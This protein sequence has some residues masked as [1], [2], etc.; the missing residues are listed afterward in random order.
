[1]SSPVGASKTVKPTK[2]TDENIK[3][4]VKCYLDNDTEHPLFNGLPPIKNWDVSKVKRMDNLFSGRTDF[5]EDLSKWKVENVTNMSSMFAGCVNFK[6]NLSKWKVSKV[7]FMSNMFA[8]CVEFTSNLS[9]WDVSAVTDMNHMFTGCA[10]FTSDVSKWAVD[11]VNFMQNMFDGCSKFN[12]NVSKWNV[13]NVNNFDAMFRGCAIFNCDL[14]NWNVGNAMSMLNMFADCTNFT[15]DLCRWDTQKATKMTRK[16]ISD[17]YTRSKLTL[18]TIPY[19]AAT[20][21][22]KSDKMFFAD[23]GIIEHQK[24]YVYYKCGQYRKI[25]YDRMT[26]CDAIALYQY[27]FDGYINNLLRTNSD[28]TN[29]NL[30]EFLHAIIRV[31]DD[32]HAGPAPR[33]TE[34]MVKMRQHLVYRGEKT[35]CKGGTCRQGIMPSYTSSSTN[36]FIAIGFM[37]KTSTNG[38]PCCLYE[39]ALNVGTPY[40]DVDSIMAN[41]RV[42]CGAY[43]NVPLGQERE[44]ILPRGITILPYK[45]TTQSTFS[46]SM[47]V[48]T[49]NVTYDTTYV[50]NNSMSS[51]EKK[52]PTRKSPPSKTTVTRRKKGSKSSSR[53]SSKSRSK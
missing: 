17:F 27:N 3:D 45:S 35:L 34:R 33:V 47:Q 42:N 25:G 41:T 44:Y 29:P 50:A 38:K 32:Y 19:F 53:R 16:N 23:D 7:A 46:D 4:C 36:A 39:Y 30:L 22:P 8:G 20:D 15:S 40:I 12:G 48:F 26:I 49:L 24:P 31:I 2:I 11:N 10:E 52:T 5:N 1:M 51:S 28:L 9:K 21:L 37:D 14:S 6:S 13:S 18:E 43:V